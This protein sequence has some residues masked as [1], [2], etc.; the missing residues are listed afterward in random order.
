VPT[1][2]QSERVEA[3]GPGSARPSTSVTRTSERGLGEGRDGQAT[4]FVPAHSPRGTTEGRDVSNSKEV[5][6][7]LSPAVL[8]AIEAEAPGTVED[9]VRLL[10]LQGLVIRRAWR[11][12]QT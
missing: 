9:E 10:A 12:G 6:V 5:V 11:E 2:A 4:R 7:R 8:A 1:D 3:G